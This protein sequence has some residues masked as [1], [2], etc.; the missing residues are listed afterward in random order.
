MTK[1]EIQQQ[2]TKESKT[3]TPT[4]QELH[5]F[6]LNTN[7]LVNLVQKDLLLNLRSNL[8]GR[9]FLANHTKKDIINYLQAPA[10]SEKMLRQISNLLYNL[11]PQYKRLLHYISGMAR[12]DHVIDI[13]STSLINTTNEP[14]E[15]D[16]IS[17][18]YY[19]H[20]NFINNMN[21]KHEFNKILKIML[22]E[23][24]FFGYDYSTNNS[25]FIQKLNPE[26]CRLH[27]WADGTRVFQFDFT[28]FNN[29]YNRNLLETYYAPEFKE[30]YE[31]Y[32]E[33]GKDYRWQELDTDRAICLKFN[34]ETEYSVPFFAS[35]FPD[36]FDLQD[37][38]LLHKVNVEMQNS[39]LIVG[40][41]PYLKSSEVSNSF[42]LQ[43][44]DAVAFGQKIIQEIPDFSSFLLSPYESVDAI[45]LGDKN[46]MLK[47]PV[48]EAEASFW[49]SSGVNMAIFNSDKISEESIRKSIQAD[50]NV[51]FSVYR[52]FER[53]LNRKIKLSV[54]SEFRVRILDTTQFNYGEVFKRYKEAAIYGIPVKRELYA[55]LGGNPIDMQSAIIMENEILKLHD[56]LNPLISSNTQSGASDNGRPPQDASGADNTG[57]KII[58]G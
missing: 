25:Y 53:W 46:S 29:T 13:N 26:F 40:K 47:N 37:Y 15:P 35:V 16:K 34:E 21:I 18:K 58:K 52:Q 28:F 4:P 31:K 14:K 43:L 45:H 55:S 8:E 32:K 6:K 1:Q 51:I 44:D 7:K 41:I 2:E 33:L 30:R 27:G 24:T 19:K 56:V 10:T 20:A 22:L 9:T 5:Y 50:E 39:V 54:D 36:I 23:D 12:F 17:K 42:A 48:T 11:S 38:K 3:E 49:S 57:K